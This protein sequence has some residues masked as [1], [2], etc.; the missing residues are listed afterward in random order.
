MIDKLITKLD[1]DENCSNDDDVYGSM[2]IVI[3]LKEAKKAMRILLL[4]LS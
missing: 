4:H 3:L 1:I 2:V